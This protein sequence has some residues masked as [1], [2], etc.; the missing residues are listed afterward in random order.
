MKT[1]AFFQYNLLLASVKGQFVHDETNLV[2]HLI[3]K[4]FWG[5]MYPLSIAL[6]PIS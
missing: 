4:I 1:S 2:R 3:F 6:P 5:S